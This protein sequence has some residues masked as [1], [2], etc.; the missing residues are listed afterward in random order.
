MQLAPRLLP[1][2]LWGHQNSGLQSSPADHFAARHQRMFTAV[3]FLLSCPKLFPFLLQLWFCLNNSKTHKKRVR[4]GSYLP[5]PL[6]SS[7][8]IFRLRRLT[9]GYFRLLQVSRISSCIRDQSDR[10]TDRQIRNDLAGKSW[11]MYSVSEAA[12]QRDL[13][14]PGKDNK[15]KKE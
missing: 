14:N 4:K 13:S 8:M 15:E 6:F 11:I 10:R 2:E 1:E 5:L 7:T 9:P 3:P 12:D